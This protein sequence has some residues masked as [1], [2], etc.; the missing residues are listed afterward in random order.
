MSCRNFTA[1]LLCLI[2]LA[3]FS[4]SV[5]ADPETLAAHSDIIVVGK[6]GNR[7]SEW[8]SD[9]SRI[10]TRVTIAVNDAIK[11]T[12]VPEAIEVVVPGGEVD[13]VGEWYSHTT[14]FDQ[15]EDVVV[16]AK[17]ESPGKYSVAGGTAGKM[18]IAQDP[19]TGRKLIPRFGSLKE[20]TASLRKSVL[21]QQQQPIRK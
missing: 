14:R 10:Q 2:P 18:T 12:S 9:H 3:A 21:S 17:N 8:N 13:G 19:V 1:F 5:P 6:V 4:Q 15:N 7:V 16:F 20:F 11:G